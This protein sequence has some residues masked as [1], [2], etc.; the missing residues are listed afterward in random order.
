MKMRL[1]GKSKVFS[2]M[3][4]L[5]LFCGLLVGQRSISSPPIYISFLWH[6]HQP[7]YWPYESIVTTEYSGG[8]DFSVIDVHDQRSGPYTDW[9]IHAVETGMSASSP[10]RDHFGVQVSF[11]GSLMENLDN[12][13]AHGDGHFSTWENRWKQGRGYSTALGNPRIDM[14]AF[15]YH[16][17]IMP[18]IDA[19]DLGLQ[20]EAHRQ[21]FCE[22][23]GCSVPYSQGLFPPENGFGPEA[24]PG[25]S[26]QGVEWVMVDN[27]HLQRA[28]QG[29]PWNSGGGVSEPNPADQINPDPGDWVSLMDL[30]APT[31]VSAQWSYQ[32]HWAEY[33]DPQTGQAQRIIVVPTARYMGNEDGRGGFGALQYDKGMSQLEPY[34]TDPDHPILIVL[35]HDGDNH[36]AGSDS[37]Y[38]HNFQNF[39]NWLQSN[40]GRFVCTTVEDYLAMFPPASADVIHFEDGSWAGA[41]SGD[42][43]YKKWLGDPGSGE[44]SSDRNSWAALVAAGNR[45]Q[46]A[47]AINP[48][49]THTQQAWHY[50]LNGQTS[51]YFYWDGQDPWD[52]HPTRA[53]NMAVDEAGWVIGSGPDTVGPTLF[54]PQREPYNPGGLEWGQTQPSEFTVWTFAY[55]QAGVNDCTLYYR[56]DHDGANP[57]DSHDNETYA[58]GAEVGAWVGVP[59]SAQDLPPAQTDPMPAYR[60]QLYEA[61][62]AG[63]E[64]VLLDYYVEAYDSL[65]NVSRSAIKH[66]YVGVGSGSSGTPAVMWSPKTP[67]AGGRLAIYYDPVSGALPDD[68]NPVFIHIGH[69]GWQGILAPDPEMSLCPLFGHFTPLSPGLS[70]HVEDDFS[71]YTHLIKATQ[72]FKTLPD[73]TALPYKLRSL[74]E[75]LQEIVVP[76]PGMLQLPPSSY[77]VYLFDIPA[78]ATSIDFVFTDGMGHWDNNEGRDW[79]VQ[80]TGTR[81]NK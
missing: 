4:V 37:Y 38:H 26:A 55:D 72:V 69:S 48:F 65:G 78:Y 81:Q 41:D 21:T 1:T 45:V 17:P 51:C 49:S 33:V 66:V 77:W 18:L 50:L 9:P 10:T 25:I 14:V 80:C 43:E 62:I 27:F 54:P 31:P 22:N 46:T 52:S 61:Q 39:V 70:L 36:G 19:F 16:H 53:A 44:Y 60:A 59:M 79:H 76:I 6:M 12:L 63:Q 13:K 29:Y 42:P 7:I 8:Y 67:E 15:G 24:I 68:T 23:F 71:G 57:L 40:P 64:E 32:P 28:C 30:W 3:I 73:E 74:H 20:I 47:E 11:S 34:N 75:G 2:G 35:H 56:V 5:I 58:G